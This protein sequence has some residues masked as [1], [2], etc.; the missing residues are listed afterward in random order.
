VPAAAAVVLGRY[1]APQ[2][3]RTGEIGEYQC[4]TK[5]PNHTIWLLSA[6]VLLSCAVCGKLL[7]TLRQVSILKNTL[8]HGAFTPY[9]YT[10]RNLCCY[11]VA[12]NREANAKCVLVDPVSE[13]SPFY[14]TTASPVCEYVTFVPVF[15]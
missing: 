7:G 10:V 3:Q 2:F 8:N 9:I 11:L 6:S 1:R 12:I 13:S 14:V 15:D 4:R 5:L